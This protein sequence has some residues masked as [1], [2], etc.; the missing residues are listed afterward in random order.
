MAVCRATAGIQ[1][2]LV[3]VTEVRSASNFGSNL[4][5]CPPPR[6]VI[7]IDKR[8]PTL[9]S[10]PLLVVMDH[11][12]TKFIT[13]SANIMGKATQRSGECFVSAAYCRC[14][15][16]TNATDR[17]LAC[18]ALAS[19]A[20]IDRPSPDCRLPPHRDWVTVKV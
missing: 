2:Y 15:C 11:A 12:T 19:K 14:K 13:R 1:P 16:D 17:L 18:F 7:E 3:T 5:S 4:L 10:P 20:L 9:L 8:R 6:R